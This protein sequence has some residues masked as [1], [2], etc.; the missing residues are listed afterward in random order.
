[1][2]ITGLQI[3][4]LAARAAAPTGPGAVGADFAAGQGYALSLR[5]DEAPVGIAVLRGE[6]TALLR[7]LVEEMLI[8]A[9]PRG[10]TGL[11][12][13]MVGSQSGGQSSG[14][15]MQAIAALDIAL[16]DL[17][18]KIGGEPLWKSLGGA[19]PRVKVHAGSVDPLSDDAAVVQWYESKA[20]SCGIRA[21]KLKLGG[22]QRANLRRLGLM[23]QAL[24]AQ[25]GGPALMVDAAGQW[26]PKEAIRHIGEME[27][28]F[29]LTWVETPTPSWDFLGLK[30]VSSG[31][32]AAVCAGA[33]IEFPTGFLPHLQHHS[34]D[35]VQIDTA[36]VGITGA[37]Q[38]ADAAYGF[39][40]P[41]ALGAS[42]GNYHAHLAAV[43]PYCASMEV[44]D[45][46]SGPGL[47][48]T[49]VRIEQGWAVA[50]DRPGNGLD[51]GQLD[52]AGSP[53]GA[54]RSGA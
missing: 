32:R 28:Q 30:R 18:A 40:L 19:R 48:T 7:R 34:L 45:A 6:P 50:G 15:A 26:S 41:I 1:V 49:D 9:D 37:L 39:E 5:T 17:K 38:L 25:A 12:Q 44:V 42:P 31:I 46:T 8:G 14:G 3:T 2:K 51:L 21:G 29:D 47:V 35:V 10:V 16:W 13:R 20:R 4:S 43:M 23:Q 22:D 52:P 33:N 24:G 36:T 54:A 27:R 53:A 11:W